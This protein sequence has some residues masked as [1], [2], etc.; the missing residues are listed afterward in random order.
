M[1][2]NMK[3]RYIPVYCGGGFVPVLCGHSSHC[4]VPCGDGCL[5]VEGRRKIGA[6]ALQYSGFGVIGH[7]WR[8]AGKMLLGNLSKDDPS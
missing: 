2:Y 8:R 7:I 4:L 1:C 3:E 6:K 5:D